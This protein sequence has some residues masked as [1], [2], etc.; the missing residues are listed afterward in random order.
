VVSRGF[1]AKLAKEDAKLAK[2][3]HSFS[4]KIFLA[5][6]APWREKINHLNSPTSA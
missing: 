6:L 2:K 5:L 1:L 4:E 3:S